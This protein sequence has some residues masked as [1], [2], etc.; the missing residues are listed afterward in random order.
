M[1]SL[2]E[3]YNI[4]RG[5]EERGYYKVPGFEKIAEMKV[6]PWDL[7]S[8]LALGRIFFKK[9][10]LITPGEHGVSGVSEVL[11]FKRPRKIAREL[12]SQF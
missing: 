10:E 4:E 3:G 12:Y 5:I 1:V 2:H 8:Q 6:R 7:A 11:V 9:A